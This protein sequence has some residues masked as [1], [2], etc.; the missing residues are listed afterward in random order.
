MVT[1]RA[2]ITGLGI[3]APNGNG[4]DEYWDALIHGRSG[5]RKIASFDPSPFSTQIAG[6]VKNFDPCDYFDP[7]LVKRSGRFTHFGV[8]TA[9][10]AVADSGI[11][12]SRENRDRFGVCF[13]STIGAE[14]D[15]YEGQHK[16]FLDSGPKAVSR[17]TAP[18]F[19]PHVTTGYICSELNIAGPNSTLCSGCSTGLDVVNWGY[20]MVKQGTVDVAIVGS[21]D[22]PIF[23]F[24]MATFCALGILSKRNEEPEVASRPY[25]KDRDGM[26]LSEG[27]AAIVIEEL[28]HAVNRGADIYAEII[29][30]ASASDGQDVVRVDANG[31]GLVTALEQALNSG[32]IRKEE[33]DYICAHGNAIPSYDVSETNAFKSF[34]GERAYKIPISSIKS[35]TGQAYAAGGS[36]QV[37]ATSLMIKN[38]VISPT[39]NLD[40]PDSLCDLDYVPHHARY[41]TMDT[42]LINSHSVGGTH[43]V[44]VLRKYL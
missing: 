42:V 28:N 37:V 5:I 10:M 23:P 27:G 11:N 31:L 13:G 21:A 25:D 4:K 17:F 43:A 40:V 3:L 34:F 16:K 38:G 20:N 18:E 8:A 12:L 29:S 33:I 35:M 9:K 41:F 6:E 2:V 36:F 32:K 39:I 22:A 30:Y 44:L 15:I 26:V 24:A 14:N 1:R 19:T 7:K